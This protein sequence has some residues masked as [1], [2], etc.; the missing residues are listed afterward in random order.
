MSGSPSRLRKVRIRKL[1]SGFPEFLQSVVF[2]SDK[3]EEHKLVL[4][5]FAFVSPT[6]S[7]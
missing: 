4:P 6:H 1:Q 2:V 5:L 7:L 3:K